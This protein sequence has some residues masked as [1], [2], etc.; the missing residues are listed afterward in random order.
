MVYARTSDDPGDRKNYQHLTG[1]IVEKGMP[2]FTVEKINE[3]VGFDNIQN[4][5]L[6][7]DNVAVPVSSRIGKEGEGWRVMTAG[8][9]FERTL[10]C[11]QVLGWTREL[12]RNV[13]PYAQRRVQFGRP[14]IE[15]TNNQ[16]KIADLIMQV[17]IARQ[18]TYYTAYLWDLG[19]DITLESNA[20]KVFIC[21]G[22]M[23]AALDA[24]QVMEGSVT[25]LPFGG[26]GGVENIAGG[27]MEACRLRDLD[28]IERW[29]IQD[30][31]QVI[32]ENWESRPASGFLKRIRPLMRRSFSNSFPKTIAS[33]PGST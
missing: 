16:F 12:L 15:F 1:F 18:L 4:G 17:S 14:T 26:H 22:A 19:W 11:A 20:A 7:F 25:F 6:D 29:P 10:I 30:A 8:L 24:I 9:N 2:G 3:I 13:V 23:K 5:V 21:E 31:L 28:R 33:T 32:H 27:T